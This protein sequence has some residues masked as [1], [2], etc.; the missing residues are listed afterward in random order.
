MATWTKAMRDRMS[1]TKSK[2]WQAKVNEHSHPLTKAR[3]LR[4]LTERELGLLAGGVAQSTISQI[5][6]GAPASAT[7]HEKLARVLNLPPGELFT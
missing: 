1:A 5:E 3:R 2:Y 6:H 4:D 7:T